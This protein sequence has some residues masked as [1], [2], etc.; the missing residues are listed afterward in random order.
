[1]IAP[2]KS[3]RLNAIGRRGWHDDNNTRISRRIRTRICNRHVYVHLAD[4]G[5]LV[6]ACGLDRGATLDHIDIGVDVLGRLEESEVAL[7]ELVADDVL[8]DLLLDE[9]QL[10]AVE[11]LD[12]GAL[13]GAERARPADHVVD[14]V[15]QR[16]IERLGHVERE[17][18]AHD[19]YAAVEERWRARHQLAQV[20][21]GDGRN[22]RRY[23]AREETYAVAEAAQV[24]GKEL[25]R[26]Y[27]HGRVGLG[28]NELGEY[29]DGELEGV[30][31]LHAVE[32]LEQ[33]AQEHEAGEDER[34]RDGETT[35]VAR[36]D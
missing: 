15:G 7:D 6:V 22:G 31:L 18:A 1:M 34:E 20:D 27:D 5:R 21:G 12:L 2:S 25:G 9:G 30:R 32:H 14:A 24:G 29:E 11:L 17:Q 36:Y 10:L 23:L 4:C 8:R 26:V 3:L 16:P 33:S 35:S 19:R 28:D 13:L